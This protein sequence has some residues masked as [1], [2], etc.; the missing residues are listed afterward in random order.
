MGIGN[1]EIF[2]DALDRAVFAKGTMK[3][4]ERDVRLELGKHR[5]DIATDINPGDPIPHLLERIGTGISGRQGHRP[6]GRKPAH[7]DSDMLRLHPRQSPL[8]SEHN[9]LFPKT[10]SLPSGS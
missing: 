9:A 3:R 1:A 8:N 5:A 2:E 10:E 4:I 7:Q 6:L